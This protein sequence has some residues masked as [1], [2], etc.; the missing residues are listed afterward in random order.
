M[1]SG[2]ENETSYQLSAYDVGNYITYEINSTDNVFTDSNEVINVND[3]QNIVTTRKFLNIVGPV[4]P[5]EK[6]MKIYL[7]WLI[8]I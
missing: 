6:H 5:C 3:D 8:L 7:S 2:Y 1:I 4:L